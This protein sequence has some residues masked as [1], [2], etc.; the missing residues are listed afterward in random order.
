MMSTP[1]KPLDQDEVNA[2]AERVG[3]LPPE[4]AEWVGRLLN[5]MLRARTHEAELFGSRAAPVPAAARGDLD[6]RL[7][8]LALDTAEWLRTLWNVGYMGAGNFPAPPRSAFPSIDLDDIMKSSLFARI[9]Q[10]KHALPFP[11]PTRHGIPWHELLDGN[12]EAHAVSA[13][14]VRDE[15]GLSLGAIIDGCPD[16]LIVSEVEDRSEFIVQHQGKGPTYRLCLRPG[17]IA[18]LQRQPPTLTRTILRQERGGL[19]SHTLVWP[20]DN[21]RPPQQ[22]ALRAV[23]WERAEAEAQ[24]WLAAVHPDLYGQVSFELRDE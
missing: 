11:P 8:Q 1:E 12:A 6:E 3:T 17:K 15:S 4:H 2:L 24:R 13:E 5:E 7:A 20:G 10:G 21:G 19:A 14:V 22:V 23:T 16:W 18:D 9:R